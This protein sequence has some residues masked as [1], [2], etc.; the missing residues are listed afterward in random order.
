LGK[1]LAEERREKRGARK[2]SFLT[3]WFVGRAKKNIGSLKKGNEEVAKSEG[4]RR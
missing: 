3:F 4:G 1:R 2:K